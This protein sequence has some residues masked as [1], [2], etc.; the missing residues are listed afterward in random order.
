[1]IRRVIATALTVVALM[2]TVTCGGVSGADCGWNG[3]AITFP[4]HGET[5]VS[6][7]GVTA[8]LIEVRD[9]IAD[10]E[11]AGVRVR[12]PAGGQSEAGEY[13]VSV[14]RVTDEGVTVRIQP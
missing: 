9:G 5:S 2:G 3:C 6:V 8:R 14:E 11:V 12:L 10:L 1:M 4:R 13:T 7:L